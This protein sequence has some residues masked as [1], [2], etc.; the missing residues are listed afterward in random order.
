MRGERIFIRKTKKKYLF[1]SILLF[2]SSRFVFFFID[3]V[4]SL[5]FFLNFFIYFFLFRERVKYGVRRVLV[6]S[7]GLAQELLV[8]RRLDHVTRGAVAALARRRLGEKHINKDKKKKKERKR[9]D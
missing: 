9:K 4:N 1:S 8:R 3:L 2:M 6:A 7:A 5:L